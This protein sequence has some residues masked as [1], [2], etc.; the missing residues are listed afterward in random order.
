MQS[1][2]FAPAQ[3]LK[4]KVFVKQPVDAAS[5]SSAS[6]SRQTTTT[7]TG[8][9]FFHWVDVA[10]L[11]GRPVRLDERDRVIFSIPGAVPTARL[12][13]YDHDVVYTAIGTQMLKVKG[14]SRPT[15]SPSVLRVVSMIETALLDPEVGEGLSMLTPCSACGFDSTSA[16]RGRMRRCKLCLCSWHKSCEHIM[17]AHAGTSKAAHSV[18]NIVFP[19]CIRSIGELCALCANSVVQ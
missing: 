3:T 19:D 15:V 7:F 8:L 18:T 10:I 13:D 4:R 11:H 1:R 6:G 2:T 16:H 5:S 12:S 17:Y 14:A 9:Q